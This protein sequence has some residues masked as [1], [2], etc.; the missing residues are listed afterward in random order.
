MDKDNPFNPRAELIFYDSLLKQSF[1]QE[2]LFV[3]F[4]YRAFTLLKLGKETEAAEVLTNIFNVREEKS[5][6]LSKLIEENLAL[7]YLRL[8]ER[9]NCVNNHGSGSFV[10]PIQG[11]GIY[12]DP[13]ATLN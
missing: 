12:T 6:K 1:P 3:I 4:A 8:G 13:Y 7:S 9:N 2:Q 10:F 11:N 5:D